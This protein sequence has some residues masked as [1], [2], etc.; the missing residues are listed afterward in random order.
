[1][2]LIHVVLVISLSLVESLPD[3]SRSPFAYLAI[4]IHSDQSVVQLRAQV[5]HSSLSPFSPGLTTLRWF[6]DRQATDGGRERE[7]E[8]ERI[9]SISISEKGSRFA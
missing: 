4:A 3:L 6:A 7:R 2:R 8:R 9:R 5:S 1:M